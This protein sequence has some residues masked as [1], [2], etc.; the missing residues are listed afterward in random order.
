VFP[1]L[2]GLTDPRSELTDV[3]DDVNGGRIRQ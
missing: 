3:D 1:F 2:L